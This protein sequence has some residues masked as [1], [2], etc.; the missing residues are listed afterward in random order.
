MSQDFVIEGAVLSYPHLFQASVAK[1]SSEARFGASLILPENYDWSQCQQAIQEAIAAQWPQGTDQSKLRMPF[2]VVNEGP[3]AGRYQMKA[4]SKA[5]RPPQIVM[6]N[7]A[8]KAG[9]HQSGEFFAGCIVNAYVRAF[10]YEQGGVSLNLNAVQ[11]V[12]NDASLPRLDSQRAATEVFQNIPGGPAPTAGVPGAG[13]PGAQPGV[14]AGAGSAQPA[15]AQPA[16]VGQPSPG[17][18]PAG[19]PTQAVP[20]AAPAMPA[21][22]AYPGVP[23]AGVPTGAPT[24]PANAPAGMPWNQQ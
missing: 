9:P 3:Y 17:M 23:G 10:G 14:P 12:N 11:L 6:Q 5:D 20:A 8:V 1:G 18:M 15:M 21:Q 4:Y 24:G 2:D 13:F 19:M 22:G 16:P 7:P